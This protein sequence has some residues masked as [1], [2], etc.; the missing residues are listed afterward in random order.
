MAA[1]S[2]ETNLGVS[3][4]VGGLLCYVPCCIG[5]IFSIVAVVVEKQSKFLR[6]HALQSLLLHA[7]LLVLSVA[8]TILGFILAMTHLGCIGLVLTLFRVVLG[9]AFL[10]LF[11]FLMIKAN[12]GEETELPII[13]PMAKSWA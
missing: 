1:S 8:L 13:G 11:V 5:F 3:P 9:L 12:G 4:N 2:G 7:V 6:F 10:G